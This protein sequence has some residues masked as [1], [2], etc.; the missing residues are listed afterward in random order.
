MSFCINCGAKLVDGAKFCHNCGNQTTEVAES[1]SQR[2][3]EYVGKILKCSS[4]GTVITE[5]TVVCP[6]CGIQI[7]SREANSTVKEFKDQ[8]M[9][10]EFKR[11]KIKLPGISNKTDSQ[12]LALIQTFPIPNAIDDIQE[13]M[14]LAIANINTKLSKHSAGSKLSN[15]MNSNDKNIMMQKTISDAWVAK[16]QQTFHKAQILFPNDPMFDEM[17]RIYED[18]LKELKIKK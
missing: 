7:T 13:F 1:K 14:L 17:K 6:E 11:N 8:L 4:C 3:Q 15:I 2:Q 12:K 18:T 5:S 16:M 9:A 10:I